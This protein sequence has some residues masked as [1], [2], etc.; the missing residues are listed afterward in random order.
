MY[1]PADII[2]LYS[3]YFPGI[4][5]QYGELRCAVGEEIQKFAAGFSDR[6][7]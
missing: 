1:D 4:L 2:L 5:L 7:S 3:G 6:R